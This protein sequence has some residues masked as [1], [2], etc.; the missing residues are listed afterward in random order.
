M[1]GKPASGAQSTVADDSI[2]RS[3]KNPS[4]N[5]D[6]LLG[7]VA[8]ASTSGLQ[9]KLHTSCRASE[10]PGRASANAL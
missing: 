6:S 10:S 9:S 4:F 1:P 7:S 2:F 8:T 5:I 3:Y